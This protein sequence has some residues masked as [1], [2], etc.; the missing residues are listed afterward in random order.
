MPNK[1]GTMPL[2]PITLRLSPEQQAALDAYIA[3]RR[4]KDPAYEIGNDH[5]AWLMRGIG[6]KDLAAPLK[7][8]RPVKEKS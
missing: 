5:R 4:E 2:A 8:G 7:R 6:R 3:E 1:K